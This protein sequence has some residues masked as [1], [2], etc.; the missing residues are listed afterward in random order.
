MILFS[1]PPSAVAQTYYANVYE[2]AGRVI[3]GE[4]WSSRLTCDYFK[5]RLPGRRAI[6]RLV[7]RM[8]VRP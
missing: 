2:E 4:W 6:Y 5:S 1:M 8:K 3:Y 7:V